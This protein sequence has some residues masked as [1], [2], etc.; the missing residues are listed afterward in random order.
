MRKDFRE[1]FTVKNVFI[2][3]MLLLFSVF[4]FGLAFG[5]TIQ[6]ATFFANVN[7]LFADYFNVISMSRD[8]DPYLFHA[9]ERLSPER[10][11]PPLAYLIFQFL[12]NLVEVTGGRYF[13]NT[14]SARSLF[15]AFCIIF[16]W[17]AILFF[18]FYHLIKGNT[19]T[20]FFTA[21]AL[22]LSGIM[23]FSLERGNIVLLT[24]VLCNFFLMGYRSENRWVRHLSY[25]ALA[26]AASL[27]VYPALLGLLVLRQK[28]FREAFCLAGYG[29]LAVFV[30]FFFVEGGLAN[31]PQLLANANLN[32][33]IYGDP[34][35]CSLELSRFGYQLFIPVMQYRW[36]WVLSLMKAGTLLLTILTPLTFWAH[37]NHWKMVTQLLLAIM[38]F[39]A[40]NPKY[41]G[42]YLFVGLLFFLNESRRKW[43]DYGYM[44]LFV[45]IL[46]PCQFNFFLK[47]ISFL[48]LTNLMMNVGASLLWVIL[49]AEAV[50]RMVIFF[51][52]MVGRKK[53]K[54]K[55]AAVDAQV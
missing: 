32:S 17:A 9:G 41:V 31:L 20:K 19:A 48:S 36:S 26:L 6:N 54:A 5:R 8:G 40:N 10:A 34:R 4:F 12:G 2:F 50:Y 52:N 28:R 39:P 30:P 44:L 22:M 7:D 18:Q 14:V 38:I 15:G 16:S 1:Y 23:L 45:M 35:T 42:L 53:E 47:G 3:L 51:R 21:V 49:T 33:K 37:K 25:I 55:P 24:V 43:T 27:K 46:N 29:V 13:W 11:Y